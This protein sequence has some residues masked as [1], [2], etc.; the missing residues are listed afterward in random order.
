MS[1]YKNKKYAE[2]ITKC[3]EYLENVDVNDFAAFKEIS[4]YYKIKFDCY[5]KLSDKENCLQT[6][7]EWIKY[8]IDDSETYKIHWNRIRLY[9]FTGYG[10]KEKIAALIEQCLS[11]YKS[12]DMMKAVADMLV[13]KA[14]FYKDA[15][16][17]K[18][19][20]KIYEKVDEDTREA[21]EFAKN[22]IKELRHLK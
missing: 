6:L 7:N 8:A 17:C 2:T 20:I 22:Q 5:F 13:L 15:K 10:D 18:E 16:Y 11:Y 21:I 19:A 4:T 14:M 3:N 1:L 12:I 9:I